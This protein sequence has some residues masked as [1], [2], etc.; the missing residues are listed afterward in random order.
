MQHLLV[1]SAEGSSSGRVGPAAGSAVAGARQQ[2][3]L[4]PA[5]GA[6]SAAEGPL[7]ALLRRYARPTED[8][9]S[10]MGD[11][12]DFEAFCAWHAGVRR[13]AGKSIVTGKHALHDAVV[14]LE[15]LQSALRLKVQRQELA[16]L[17]APF[18]VK[19]CTLTDQHEVTVKRKQRVAELRRT[20]AAFVGRKPYRVVLACTSTGRLEPDCSTLESCGITDAGQEIA[21]VVGEAN[22]LLEMQLSEFL[23]LVEEHGL[24]SPA[25]VGAAKRGLNNGTMSEEL[26]MQRYL[27]PLQQAEDLRTD[28]QRWD[29]ALIQD[30]RRLREL[31][32][33]SSRC[34]GTA[35]ATATEEERMDA[36]GRFMAE[37]TR[38]QEPVV[39]FQQLCTGL[40]PQIEGLKRQVL[41]DLGFCMP[42]M[43]RAMDALG[44]FCAKDWLELKKMVHPPECVMHTVKAVLIL[45]N[46]VSPRH[47]QK[48]LDFYWD[49]A[50]KELF[51]D[52][53]GI[54]NRLLEYD[55]DNVD[56]EAV[57]AL[58]PYIANDGL[59]P[60]R[61][62][63]VSEPAWV[64]CLWVHAMHSYHIA[65][66]RA[67]SKSVELRGLDARLGAA[68]RIMQ[69]RMTLL[70]SF[71]ADV[72]ELQA[73]LNAQQLA[74]GRDA[75]APVVGA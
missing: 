63:P 26:C 43:D 34:L 40:L 52:C 24:A 33:D 66:R 11:D 51:T 31:K 68:T 57:R 44:G 53:Y 10:A 62:K 7:A 8:A 15:S 18:V 50:Q 12:M 45:L 58:D 55:K 17:E 72:A 69:L 75:P 20:A 6:A 42:A 25:A 29:D 36:L 39:A 16:A 19:L 73:G 1:A 4:R 22:P 47:Q 59:S 49:I 3:G 74:R 13:E 9:S 65:A 71:M 64:L 23:D 61:I 27:Q 56:P 21:V 48:Q 38:F 37:R 30:E 46:S 67:E 2:R 28:R 5:S 60:E 41:A 14:E 35:R 54:V 70:Q 32:A